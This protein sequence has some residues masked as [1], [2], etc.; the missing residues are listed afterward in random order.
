MTALLIFIGTYTPDG[1]PGGIHAVPFD[2]VAGTFGTPRLAAAAANP[3]FLVRHPNGRILYALDESGRVEGKP[4]GAVSAFAIDPDTGGLTPLNTVPSGGFGGAHV[5][6]DSS[7][8]TVTLVSYHGSTVTSFPLGADGR[9]GRPV[10]HLTVVGT[11]GPNTARQDKPHPHSLTFSPDNRFAYVC[12]LGT[13][14]ILRYRI[15][16][17]SSRLVPDGTTA[18]APGAGPRHGK[19]TADGRQFRVINE[20]DSTIATYGCD[21]ATGALSLR[22]TIS[23]LPA[24]FHGQSICAEIRIHPNGR[25]VYGSNRGHDSL[26]VFSC[27]VRTGALTLVQIEPCGGGHP[28]NFAL[29]PDGHWLVCANRDSNNLVL[30]AVDPATGRLTPTG[31]SVTI[32]QP[33]CVLMP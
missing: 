22:Q 33:V 19:F 24:D 7:G 15:D 31:R 11:P 5:A 4:G 30:F 25:F 16:P 12:D 1:N 10:S 20:L 17:A 3:T 2:P 8:R 14:L 28:R 21:P 9:I 18:T 13:D 23:T 29:T 6:V 32:P 26:A 27:D